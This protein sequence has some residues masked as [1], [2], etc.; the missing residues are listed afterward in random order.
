MD[1][2]D[3]KEDFITPN[4]LLSKS[5]DVYYVFAYYTYCPHCNA[6]KKEVFEFASK[7]LIKTYFMKMDMDRGAELFKDVEPNGESKIEFIER[8]I[9]DSIG[10]KDIKDIGF[11]FVPTLFVIKNNVLANMVILEDKISSF[12]KQ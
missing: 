12:L 6:V 4:E 9:H 2:I 11:Y 10:M 1:Y 8:Y 7:N 5:E 3:F